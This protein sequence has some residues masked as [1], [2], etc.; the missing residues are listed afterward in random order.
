MLHVSILLELNSMRK[1]G[2]P[3]IAK[4]QSA[5]HQEI[6]DWIFLYSGDMIEIEKKEGE[7]N[8]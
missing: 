8:G 2:K 5:S 3:R 1:F 4:T 6:H 7:G